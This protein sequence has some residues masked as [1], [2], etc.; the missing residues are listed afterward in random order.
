MVMVRQYLAHPST[1]SSCSFT[2]FFS[3]SLS[4]LPLTEP[5]DSIPSCLPGCHISVFC[6]SASQ[7]PCVWNAPD[8]RAHVLRLSLPP[9]RKS[10]STLLCFHLSMLVLLDA[11]STAVGLLHQ[12]GSTSRVFLHL[13]V[14]LTLWSKAWHTAEIELNSGDAETTQYELSSKKGTT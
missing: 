7:A 1:F 8:G 3:G 5:A 14:P 9:A 13:S 10:F 4:T 11:S 6:L 2:S 12:T